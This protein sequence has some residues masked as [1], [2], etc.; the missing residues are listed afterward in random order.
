[1]KDVRILFIILAYTA[2]TIRIEK[3]VKRGFDYRRIAVDVVNVS[4]ER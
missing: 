4:Q 1:M 3:N 2:L